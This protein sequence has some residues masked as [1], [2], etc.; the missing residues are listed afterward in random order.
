MAENVLGTL[1][2]NIADAIRGKTG[3]TETMKPAEFPEQISNIETSNVID[4]VEIA[5]DFANGNQIERLPDGYSANSVTIFKPENLVPGN[6]AKNVNIAGVIGTHEGGGSV[7][8]EGTATVTFRN[9][10][11]TELYSRPV[12]IGDDCPE[13]VAQGKMDAPTKASDVQ[14]NYT[15]N[16]WSDTQG[17]ATSSTA[18]KNITADKTVYAGYKTSLVYYTVRFYDGDTLMQESQVAYGEMATP[19]DTTKE[20]YNFVEWTPNDF[21]ITADT[22]FYGTWEE[23]T[24]I[25]ALANPDIIPNEQCSSLVY[26]SNGER[27]IV[28][29]DNS[30]G[31]YYD[32]FVYDT[33]TKPYKL[34]K[35]WHE[36][37]TNYHSVKSLAL[38]KENTKLIVGYGTK[39]S[40]AQTMGFEVYSIS[41]DNF[42]EETNILPS[43][44]AKGSTYVYPTFS[45]NGTRMFIADSYNKYV[46]LFDTTTSPYTELCAISHTIRSTSTANSSCMVVPHT[47][48][49]NVFYHIYLDTSSCYIYKIDSATST[50]TQL[51]S[52][53]AS[54]IYGMAFSRSLER[55]YYFGKTSCTI[56][57]FDCT[58]DTLTQIK[59]VT[60]PT[61]FS[62]TA[63]KGYT[64]F[65]FSPD[66]KKM[67]VTGY[68]N[69]M[70]VYNVEN[71]NIV[72]IAK[73]STVP[74]Y[75]VASAYDS[76]GTRFAVAM[77]VSPYVLTYSIDPTVNQ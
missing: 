70:V 53:S 41:G 25:Y 56:Y 38:N 49:A 23:A 9:Y 40:Y 77:G 24:Y 28:G 16:G 4:N 1:F 71:D 48:D 19:P 46:Y 58:T 66:D 44:N 20:G 67:I 29:S 47:T 50:V 73:P 27:L 39:S 30:N 14:Y 26:S 76:T 22:D 11:G 18:L 6:I 13:P 74:S 37:N 68:A 7:S 5:L 21:T 34:K 36:Y 31:N 15:F 54:S 3:G 57:S 62:F 65:A 75:A 2:S 42:T 60:L 52:W 63:G 33:T 55:L 59:K 45:N 8:V 43:Q 51:K 35:Q 10:D 17:G 72:E 61:D 32:M 64:N 12:F 69:D